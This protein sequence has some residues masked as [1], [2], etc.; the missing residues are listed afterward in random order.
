MTIA[1][2]DY[3]SLTCSH[4][5]GGVRL[6]DGHQPLLTMIDEIDYVVDGRCANVR[7]ADGRTIAHRNSHFVNVES[8]PA[9]NEIR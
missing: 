5:M 3:V 2:V 1:E 8:D 4:A 7:F 6:C 9:R